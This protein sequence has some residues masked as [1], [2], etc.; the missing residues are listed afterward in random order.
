MERRSNG[1]RD[2][3]ASGLLF[4]AYEKTHTTFVM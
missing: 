1:N 4:I 2:K 3:G